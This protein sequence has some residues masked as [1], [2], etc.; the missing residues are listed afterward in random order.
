M[1]KGKKKKIIY[2]ANPGTNKR[3]Q[4]DVYRTSPVLIENLDSMRRSLAKQ[5]NNRMR[6]LEKAGLD[7]YAYD[8]AADYLRLQG[9][10]KDH[11][12]F[13]EQLNPK[14]VDLRREIT[15]LQG[16]LSMPTST[17]AGMKKV[18]AKRVQTF[19]DWKPKAQ[20]NN[21]RYKGID[22]SAQA[23]TKVF[24]KFL[25][26]EAFKNL[27]KFYSSEQIFRAYKEGNANIKNQKKLQQAMTDYVKTTQKKSIKGLYQSV[28]AKVIPNSENR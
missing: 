15:V 24:Y 25:N 6:A 18:E 28:G 14:G 10:K 23:Q 9:K 26:S 13:S 21:K 20:K 16:F 3:L 4:I 5:A 7:F 12:R 17:V 11:P 22:L 8:I 2:N 27:R 1:G 19:G